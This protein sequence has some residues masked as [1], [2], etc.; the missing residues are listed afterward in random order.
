MEKRFEVKPIIVRQYCDDCK[1]SELV[2]NGNILMSNPP[3]YQYRCTR[4]ERIYVFDR[5][6]PDV[7]Y[8][9]VE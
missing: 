1:D 6:Y 2:S 9:E 7:Q 8:L 5:N 4:C 3:K